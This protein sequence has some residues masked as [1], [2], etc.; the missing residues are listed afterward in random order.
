MKNVN[1]IIAYGALAATF[2]LSANSLVQATSLHKKVSEDTPD[3][4]L[5]KNKNTDTMFEVL[6]P[7]E[8]LSLTIEGIGHDIRMTDK[9]GM[10]ILHVKD[11]SGEQIR[12]IES[13]YRVISG[14]DN[15]E[16][17]PTYSDEYAKEMQADT[18]VSHSP[19]N[20]NKA[21]TES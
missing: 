19:M 21:E 1:Q 18:G 20:V 15:F 4:I 5:L 13:T 17:I 6:E 11:A 12:L 2:V 10:T 9:N 16:I 3:K 14:N 7:S 8:R